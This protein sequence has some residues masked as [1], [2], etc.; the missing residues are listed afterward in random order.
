MNVSVSNAGLSVPSRSIVIDGGGIGGGGEGGG[1]AGG[2]GGGAGMGGGGEGGG[3]EGG[4]GEGLGGGGEGG[5]GKGDGDE[6]GGGEGSGG[7]GEGGGGE[8][9]GEGG[10]GER[11]GGEGGGGATG[12]G[13]V[14]HRRVVTFG[15]STLS[16]VA[17]TASDSCTLLV[18]ASLLIIDCLSVYDSSL[19]YV[20]TTTLPELTSRSILY[21]GSDNIIAMPAT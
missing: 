14:P 17:P 7:G 4:G 2:E 18:S 15:S 20:L 10:G 3:G 11:G 5:G 19:M 8:G 21:A 1:G 16:T 13:K 9:G 12:G 6:G